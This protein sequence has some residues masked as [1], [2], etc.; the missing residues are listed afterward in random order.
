MTGTRKPRCLV[1]LASHNGAPFIREQL[2]SIL[3][4]H[5]VEA[6]VLVSDDASTDATLEIVRE[7]AATHRVSVQRNEVGSG[8]PAQN[9]SRLFREADSAGFDCIALS[10]QDDIWLPDKLLRATGMLAQRGAGGYSCSALARWPDGREAVFSQSARLRDA[11]FLFEGAGQGCTFVVTAALFRMVQQLFRKRPDLTARLI[12]H[13]WALYALARVQG[14]PWV[15]DAEPFIIYRQHGGNDTG[16]RGSVAGIRRRL[17]MFRDGRYAG[18][19]R[20]VLLLCLEIAPRNELLRRW[21]RLDSH[22][23]RLVRRAGKAVFCIRHGRRRQL[24][25]LLTA[26]AALAGWL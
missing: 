13:D 23:P 16:A 3:G 11:D 6:E 9:F 4:Q 18:Q 5:G 20:A 10:D 15:F 14:T 2:E 19:V 22:A 24:D 26:I 12:Y 8:S 25:R 21:Q 17:R 1:L 7:F